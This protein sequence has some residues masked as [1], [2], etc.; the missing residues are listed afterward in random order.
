[1]VAA[2]SG[3]CTGGGFINEVLVVVAQSATAITYE[4]TEPQDCCTI[5]LLRHVQFIANEKINHALL[6]KDFL[7]S[8][9]LA[10]LQNVT[11]IHIYPYKIFV[12][13]K[14]IHLKFI[15]VKFLYMLG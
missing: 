14:F 2:P 5:V 12:Q 15:R 8:F 9:L 11:E 10:E 13:V 7:F 6:S 1:M 4:T 3:R